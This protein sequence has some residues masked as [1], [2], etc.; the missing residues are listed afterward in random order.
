[1]QKPHRGIVVLVLSLFG[2]LG[3]VVGFLFSSVLMLVGLPGLAACII[4]FGDL[5]EMDAGRM[6]A[7]GRTI[8][9]VGLI[10][11]VLGLALMLFALIIRVLS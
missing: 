10:I 8:T 3:A 5:Y 2:I 1:M 9:K 4:A 11:A 7:S 6:D